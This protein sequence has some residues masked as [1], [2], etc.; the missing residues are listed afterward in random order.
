MPAWVAGE[1]AAVGLTDTFV[2]C[3]LVRNHRR[4]TLRGMHYQQ[5]PLA[6]TK[7]VRAIRGSIFDVAVDLRPDSPTFREWTGIQ[8][9]A[10][11]PHLFYLP[12][13]IA[14]GYQTL[15]DD[16]EVMY[17]VSS[18]YSAAHQT[19]VRWNDPA[20]GIDWPVT[21]PSIIHP[22]DASFPDFRPAP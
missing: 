1:F 7:L 10:G 15:E 12:A 22:R 4:G 13:G 9:S 16:A 17:L 3:N 20:F 6:E 2:Q 14:H 5:A 18:P 19:G 21:P 11:S 8:L